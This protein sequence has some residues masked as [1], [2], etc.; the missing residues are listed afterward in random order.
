MTHSRMAARFSACACARIGALIVVAHAG[1][2]GR[3]A[4]KRTQRADDFSQGS[5]GPHPP[6]GQPAGPGKANPAGD[7]PTASLGG[8]PAKVAPRPWN[9]TETLAALMDSSYSPQ[10]PT[11]ID[12]PMKPPAVT[13][14]TYA[15]APA[16][17]P[18]EDAAQGGEPPR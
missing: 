9:E 1:Q 16:A 17:S 7:Q 10:P 5:S 12:K 8:K 11:P 3:T 18:S 15:V 6:A 13:T 14:E 4:Q 2:G